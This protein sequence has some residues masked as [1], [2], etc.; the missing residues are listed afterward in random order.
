MHGKN[1]LIR[2]FHTTIEC[3]F[4][5]GKRISRE[6]WLVRNTYQICN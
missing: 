3:Y 1:F 2:W 6:Q 5:E 4:L